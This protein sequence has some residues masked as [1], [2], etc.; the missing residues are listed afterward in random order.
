MA[1]KGKG[2]F[3]AVGSFLGSIPAVKKV[4]K[5]AKSVK[6]KIK[7]AKKKLKKAL[8]KAKKK[9][10][11]KLGKVLT[12]ARKLKNNLSKSKLVKKFKKAVKKAVKKAKKYVKKVV[13]TVKK[14]AKTAVK[15]VKKA[16][17]TTV[18]VVKKAAVKVGGKIANTYNAFKD[19]GY[20]EALSAAVDCIPILG[21]AKA[22]Y[23]TIVGKDPITG[24][25]LEPWERVVSG[26]SV[27]GG[28]AVKI[29]KRVGGIAVGGKHAGGAVSGIIAGG[30]KGNTTPKPNTTPKNNTP[31]NQ[32]GLTN[33]RDKYY[34]QKINDAKAK[35]D[36]KAADDVRYQRYSEQKENKNEKVLD[37]KDWD[38]SNERL[39]QNR[40]RGRAE[41][42]K[43]RD[44]LENQLGRKLEDNNSDKVVTHTSSEGHLTRPD[45]IGRNSKGEIDLV[46]DHK[47]KTGGNDQTVHNDRQIRA[48]REMLEDKNGRHV[49]TISSDKPNINGVPPQPRPSG[50]LGELSDIYYTDTKSG[51]ITHQWE[52]DPLLPGGGKW[53]KI[54]K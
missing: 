28:P 29:A 27:F 26:A 47:H 5:A 40:E 38:K 42:I 2:F 54:K 6:K 20:K 30:K 9:L 3:G 43:G 36:Q 10:K 18:K 21:N 49:V 53:S 32:S 14:A 37:R 33:E 34:R 25:K 39:R 16:A 48:E 8:K 35:G 51:K 45:S 41:E 23:E 46:H 24:R 17:K 11:K 52:S 15:A 44:S 50:P 22:V 7:K 4:K 1:K 31:T 19:G 13:K 12:K